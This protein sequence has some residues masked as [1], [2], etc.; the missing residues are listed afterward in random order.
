[1]RERF[2]EDVYYQLC[3]ASAVDG[4]PLGGTANWLILDDPTEDYDDGNGVFLPWDSEMD[5]IITAHAQR[6]A[7]MFDHDFDQDGD[8]G[9]DDYVEFE[10]CLLGPGSGLR[11]GCECFD[12]DDDGDNDLLDFAAFQE[13]FTG[14]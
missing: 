5:S 3:E 1:M 14:G 13:A 10:T 7:T 9:L 12:S 4:G 11:T 6:L 8:V 2:H